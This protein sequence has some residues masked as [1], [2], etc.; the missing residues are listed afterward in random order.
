MSLP[1]YSNEKHP[2]WGIAMLL[3]KGLIGVAVLGLLLAFNYNQFDH[4]DIV[5]MILM[6]LSGTATDVAFKRAGA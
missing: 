5:T 3:A 4:R 6:F 2:L 1:W